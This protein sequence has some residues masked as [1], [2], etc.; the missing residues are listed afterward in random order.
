MENAFL[1]ADEDGKNVYYALCLL[2]LTL[3]LFSSYDKGQETCVRQLLEKQDRRAV[4]IDCNYRR[5]AVLYE[6]RQMALF[7]F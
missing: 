6:D 4:M 5:I 2:R 1:T 7:D 3:V